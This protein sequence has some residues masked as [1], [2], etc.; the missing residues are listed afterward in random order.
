MSE[1]IGK[2]FFPMYKKIIPSF[3]ESFEQFASDLKKEVVLIQQSK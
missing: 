2:L 1:K 3:D